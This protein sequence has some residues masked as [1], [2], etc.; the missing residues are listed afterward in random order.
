MH[1]KGIYYGENK[2]QKFFEFGA[3]FKYSDLYNQLENLCEKIDKN[4]QK[5]LIRNKS[6]DKP[7]K[8]PLIEEEKKIIIWNNNNIN[9]N[10]NYK[11][12]TLNLSKTI[13]IN[14][15]RKKFN[16]NN[17]NIINSKKNKNF[18]QLYNKKKK[19]ILSN[20]PLSK[21]KM[22]NSL[23]SRNK[24][25]NLLFFQNKN[26]NVIPSL[27]TQ[28][29]SIKNNMNFY[30]INK[31]D[32]NSVHSRNK[33]ILIYTVN[34]DDKRKNTLSN[35]KK[36][37]ENEI[38]FNQSVNKKF[39]LRSSINFNKKKI[40]KNNY[41]SNKHCNKKVISNKLNSERYNSGDN[42]F[43]KNFQYYKNI[44]FI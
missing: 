13:N 26:D 17:S 16:L 19:N 29:I 11:T 6:N 35:K 4:E 1:Y 31:N 44:K 43:S 37:N 39:P 14:N 30:N 22:K 36:T 21:I 10:K 9:L 3:H 12:E 32:L 20:I 41:S 34:S 24:Y 38:L 25:K 27:K 28:V 5:A 15:K 2:E 33:N 18:N 8:I 7:K 23:L 42:I 40:K